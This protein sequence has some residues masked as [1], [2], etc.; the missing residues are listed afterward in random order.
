MAEHYIHMRNNEVKEE[1]LRHFQ[2]KDREWIY[3]FCEHAGVE[4]ERYIQMYNREVSK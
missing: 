3:W 4:P 1:T 2:D